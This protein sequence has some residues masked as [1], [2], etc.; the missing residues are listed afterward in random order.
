MKK[1]LF[2]IAIV[3]AA[4]SALTFTACEKKETAGEK[5]DQAIEDTNAGAKKLTKKA[6]KA[7]EDVND[8]IDKTIKDMEK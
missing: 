8:S 4:F 3:A 5:L 2:T 1:M 6:E 7:Y